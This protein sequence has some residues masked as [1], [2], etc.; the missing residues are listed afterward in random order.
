MGELA[1]T[2]LSE[3]FLSTIFVVIRT[4][5]FLIP[6]KIVDEFFGG[7]G[8]GSNSPSK[9]RSVQMYYRFIRRLKDIKG[10]PTGGLPIYLPQSL[11]WYTVAVLPPHLGDI[12]PSLTVEVSQ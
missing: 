2:L 4:P 12:S 7:D 10:E 3:G 6:K 1:H 11:K 8:G 5:S 9:R